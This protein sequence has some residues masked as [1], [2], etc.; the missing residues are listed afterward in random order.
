MTEEKPATRI[1]QRWING[2]EKKSYLENS[3]LRNGYKWLRSKTAWK[4]ENRKRHSTL[5]WTHW[6][7]EWYDG[8]ILH[9]FM[10]MLLLYLRWAFL[11]CLLCCSVSSVLM[12]PCFYVGAGQIPLRAIKVELW[13]NETGD[14]I[15]A[16]GLKIFPTVWD[17]TLIKMN[18]TLVWTTLENVCCNQS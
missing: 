14:I 10:D 9:S 8:W 5:Y 18:I 12:F 16:S 11:L 6:H 1:C 4:K 13:S 15:W 3:Y 2:G 17:F 7:S